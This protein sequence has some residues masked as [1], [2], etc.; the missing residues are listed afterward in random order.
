M[1]V[2]ILL[3]T[4]LFFRY[5]HIFRYALDPGYPMN[6]TP[7]CPNTQVHTAHASFLILPGWDPSNAMASRTP[8][9]NSDTGIVRHRYHDPQDDSNNT[10][11]TP[12]H[13]AHG[14]D[15]FYIAIDQDAPSMSVTR[16]DGAH[17]F[18]D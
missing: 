12:I 10:Q 11:Q 16:N 15:I 6:N 1:M 13:G 17:I 2:S 14:G 8:A 3:E 4:A 18:Y 9:S 7:Q 5:I